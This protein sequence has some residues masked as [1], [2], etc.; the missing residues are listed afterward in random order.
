MNKRSTA[1]L[2]RKR[3]TASRSLR[4]IGLGLL[5]FCIAAGLFPWPQASAKPENEPAARVLSEPDEGG[6]C[7]IEGS[8]AIQQ[9]GIQSFQVYS[10][11]SDDT[12]ATL[13]YTYTGTLHVPAQISID[14]HPAA[15]TISSPLSQQ[16]VDQDFVAYGEEAWVY[17]LTD[18]KSL[19]D[20]T[21][22]AV[23]FKVDL[24]ETSVLAYG[25][26]Q[27]H[28]DLDSGFVRCAMPVSETEAEK[29]YIILL[30]HDLDA[31]NVFGYPNAMFSGEGDRDGVC[32]TYTRYASTI[33]DMLETTATLYLDEQAQGAAAAV[34]GQVRAQVISPEGER[35]Y[36]G[37]L[38]ALFEQ[39]MD[40]QR[41]ITL[42]FNAFLPGRESV[43]VTV[44][45]PEA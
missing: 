15:C 38:E 19:G 23:E 2:T 10:G 21:M 40:T 8:A 34:G 37:R 24:Q 27:M 16:S 30:G 35:L 18:S 29:A 14:G 36:T 33:D 11:D 43:T 41:T 13:A 12:E 39:A 44:E 4:A 9:T 26:S 25:F 22:L 28:V 31:F 32:T 17:T 5:V 3:F 1:G 6:L 7:C 42:Q 45:A 20:C